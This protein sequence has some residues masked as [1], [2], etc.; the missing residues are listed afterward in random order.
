MKNKK[1]VF[2]GYFAVIF[3]L[4]ATLLLSFQYKD[5]KQIE[6]LFSLSLSGLLAFIGSVIATLVLPTVPK[7][8]ATTPRIILTALR[9]I[10]IAVLV[11]FIGGGLAFAG[12]L[13]VGRILAVSGII[14]GG[15]SMS[16][17]FAALIFGQS[18]KWKE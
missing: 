13:T 7:L 8:E 5:Q 16:I 4:S 2:M 15:I 10:V 14:V 18:K 9:I 3:L 1:N 6:L 17:Y 12:F 11:S